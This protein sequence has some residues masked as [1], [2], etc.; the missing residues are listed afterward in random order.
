MSI[1]AFILV[2]SNLLCVV[3]TDSD[4]YL[5]GK[6]SGDDLNNF[7]IIGV[8]AQPSTSSD[9]GCGGDCQYLAASYVKYIE[10][11]GGRVVPIDYYS[12][13]EH[14][15][16]QFSKL[17]G[18]LFP[19]GG[20][21]FPSS[22]Q[23]IFDKTVE[24]NKAGDFAPLWGTC[25]GFQWLLVSATRDVNVLD[26]KDGTQMDAENYSIPLDFTKSASTSKLFKDS[27]TDIMQILSEK[28]VTMNN[29]H[30]GIW[31][32]SF[33][34]NGELNGFFDVLSTNKDRA[35]HE[36]VSTIESFD[37][38]IFGTQWHPEKNIF[39]WQKNQYGEPY[40]AINHSRDAVHIAQYTTNFFVDQAR[41]S[42]HSYSDKSEEDKALI[43]NYPVYKTGGS[44]VQKYYF[45]FPTN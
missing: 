6:R 20:S 28:N 17:N 11:A 21:Y 8:F 7:P 43:W 42:K 39:E 16:D 45:H 14:L 25:M 9:A 44:F 1:S 23:Y 38:P 22:A 24:A 29:H 40:E 30:Y 35:G 27:P 33:K 4:R 13:K 19:G 26:P 41:L 34:S 12:S 2:L 10:S 18:F 36:F 3:S 32:E 5:G 15:D 31:T 37:Y